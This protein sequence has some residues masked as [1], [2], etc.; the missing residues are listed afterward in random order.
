MKNTTQQQ[1]KIGSSTYTVSESNGR[2]RV[3]LWDSRQQKQVNVYGKTLAELRPK[4]KAKLA[5]FNEELQLSTNR[6]VE[7][8]FDYWL[9]NYKFNV[10]KQTTYDRLER[11]IRTLIVPYIGSIKMRAVTSDDIQKVYEAVAEEHAYSTIKK[12]HEALNG[13]FKHAYLMGDIAKNPMT[14]AK[15]P[16]EQN[17]K[18]QTKEIQVYTDI[19]IKRLVSTIDKEW[20]ENKYF[21]VAPIFVLMLNTGLRVGEAL[22]LRHEDLNLEN[23]TLSV[24]HTLSKVSIRDKNKNSVSKTEYI[25]AE[26]K[27]KTSKRTIDLNSKAIE[28]LEEEHNRNIEKGLGYSQFV[29]CSEELNHF[30]QR[31]LEDTLKRLCVRANI[32]Y[33]G[34]HALRHTFVSRCFSKGIPI[35]VISELV[36]HSSVNVTR[37]VYLHI[38]PEQKRSAIELLEAI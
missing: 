23:K 28:A 18:K 30:T 3:R 35:E 1:I 11:T 8:Y 34:I 21:R 31:S 9:K 27:T 19:E 25:L 15:P 10:L 13:C 7:Q 26:P 37:D 6:N 24:N 32:P 22:A 4:V 33:Y 29:F 12:V 17:V 5:E 36:G 38:M 14:V 2:L 16:R 20:K